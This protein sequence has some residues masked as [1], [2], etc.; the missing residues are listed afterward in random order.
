[1]AQ[2]IV[3]DIVILVIYL[4]LYFLVFGMADVPD[5]RLVGRHGGYLRMDVVVVVLIV[6]GLR[7]G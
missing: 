2:L 4:D 6:I 5:W 1:M 7:F 3:Y